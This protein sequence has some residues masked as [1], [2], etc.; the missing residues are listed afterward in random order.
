MKPIPSKLPSTVIRFGHREII[1]SIRITTAPHD[2][3][4]RIRRQREPRRSSRRC[5]DIHRDWDRDIKHLRVEEEPCRAMPGRPGLPSLVAKRGS[6]RKRR[7]SMVRRRMQGKRKRF[8][9]V[10]A[11]F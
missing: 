7:V 4:N 9:M 11:M 6:R 1:P 2:G 8:S 5:R 3:K 10:C